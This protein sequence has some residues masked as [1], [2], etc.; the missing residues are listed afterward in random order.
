M[1]VHAIYVTCRTPTTFGKDAIGLPAPKRKIR[2]A[3]SNTFFE[4]RFAIANAR[5]GLFLH[6]VSPST[7][8]TDKFCPPY[9]KHRAY[10]KGSTYCP[11]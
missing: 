1:R 5:N 3:M 2:D 6:R 7:S 10:L 4:H 9:S 11:A 8:T